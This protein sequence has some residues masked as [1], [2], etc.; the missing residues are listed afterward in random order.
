MAAQIAIQRAVEHRPSLLDLLAR[1]VVVGRGA[2]VP[3][4]RRAVGRRG[5]APHHR[6]RAVL[7]M[8]ASAVFFGLCPRAPGGAS[9]RW[10]LG[11]GRPRA[12]R[13]ASRGC[14]ADRRPVHGPFCTRTVCPKNQVPANLLAFELARGLLGDEGVL[15]VWYERLFQPGAGASVSQLRAA[16]SARALGLRRGP[17]VHKAAFQTRPSDHLSCLV[18]LSYSSPRGRPPQPSESLHL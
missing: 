11:R 5:L 13:P 12:P 15:C 3:G 6:F 7:A 18:R 4:V 9:R 16:G 1:A 8:S 17:T 2:V 10:V 14:P